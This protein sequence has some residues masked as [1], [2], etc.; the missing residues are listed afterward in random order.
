MQF[1][2]YYFETVSKKLEKYGYLSIHNDLFKFHYMY[3]WTKT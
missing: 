2:L 1:L 3:T